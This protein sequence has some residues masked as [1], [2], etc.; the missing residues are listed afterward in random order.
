MVGSFECRGF[1]NAVNGFV[2]DGWVSTVSDGLDDVSVMLNAVPKSME[3]QIATDKLLYSLGGGILCA[4][5][6][7]LLQVYPCFKSPNC[8][9]SDYDAVNMRFFASNTELLCLLSMLMYM[10]LS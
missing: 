10:M 1:K 7:M 8:I 9:G 6:S 2:D 4:K 5:A 3:G